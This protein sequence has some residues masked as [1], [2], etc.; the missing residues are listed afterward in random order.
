MAN[1]LLQGLPE[2]TAPHNGMPPCPAL[3]TV[4]EFLLQAIRIC[5][6]FQY[7]RVGPH[8]DNAVS[9]DLA[10][11][12]ATRRNFLGIWKEK[13]EDIL[14]FNRR[15]VNPVSQSISRDGLQGRIDPVN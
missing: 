4:A 10:A 9:Q 12:A 8:S 5:E 3:N 14:T 7:M 6:I 13:N 2:I 1:D 11:L 15:D